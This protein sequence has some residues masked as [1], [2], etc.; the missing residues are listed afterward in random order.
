MATAKILDR[1]TLIQFKNIYGKMQTGVA[2]DKDGQ[3]FR[4]CSFTN[5]ETGKRTYVGF[6][7][8]LGVLTAQQIAAQKNDLQVIEIQVE[9]QSK[10][11]YRLCKQGA[12]TWDDVE[13]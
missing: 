11:S 3:E 8:S 2:K 7:T 12:S 10:P 4:T 13:L 5:P 6:S 9:G 1:W